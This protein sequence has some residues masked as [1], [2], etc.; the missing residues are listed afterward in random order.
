MAVASREKAD[1]ILLDYM[2]PGPDGY[3]V[4][5][6]LRSDPNLKATPVIMLTAEAGRDTV[7][8][9]AQLGVHGYLVKPFKGELLVEK[10]GRAVELK[11]RPPT[12]Q[13]S[14][15]YDDPIGIL[16]VDNQPAILA[17]V[18]AGLSETP[19]QVSSMEDAGKALEQCLKDGVDVVLA[20]LS[21][22]NDGAFTL[23]QNLRGYAST[24]CLP[25]LGMCARAAAAEQGRAQQAGFAGVVNKPIEKAELER[26]ISR[27]LALE[28]AYKY[29]QQRN[30]VLALMLPKKFHT[31]VA[32]DVT[33]N[34][35]NQLL[36]TVNAGGNKLIID[37]KEVEA[38]TLPLVEL[39]RSAMQA[40]NRMSLRCAI[41]GTDETKTQCRR[42]AETPTWVFAGSFD[43]AVALLN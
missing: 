25:V 43:Q 20:S 14:K 1:V 42:W 32:Q 31:G 12:P 5:S 29:F 39:V 27:T 11:P 4:L 13:K 15:R 40:A 22:P 26:K 18:T 10:V 23:L 2:M 16:V 37:L 6:R 30:G 21:L 35:E 24:V 8:K 19:W 38:T 17:Q 9:I 41:V 36:G 33:A 34:L 3:E 28:T 7:I